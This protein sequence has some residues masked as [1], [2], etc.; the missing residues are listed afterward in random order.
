MSQLS[1]T[2]TEVAGQPEN[3]THVTQNFTDVRTFLNGTG[4]AGGG[5]VDATNTAAAFAKD[6][7]EPA[8]ERYKTLQNLVT[9]QTALTAATVAMNGIGSTSTGAANVGIW[10]DPADF[11]AGSRSTK[12]RIRAWMAVNATAPAATQTFG[13]YPVTVAGG[14]GVVTGTLGTVVSG[15]TVAIASP[16]AST[17]TQAVSSDFTPPVAGFY[18][19]GF[20]VSTGQAA[21]T[22]AVYGTSLQYRQV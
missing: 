12:Y 18:T 15:S 3:I 6:V 13:L 5:N 10:L 19:V 4:A 16:T 21:N 2:Y 9:T 8:F 22:A 17:V 14:S 11:T 20:V 1:L 7:V